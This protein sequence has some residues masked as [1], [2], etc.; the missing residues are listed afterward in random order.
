MCVATTLRIKTFSIVTL[1]KTK[2]TTLRMT[3]LLAF[4]LSVAF[5]LLWLMPLCKVSL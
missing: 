3:I 1:S 4:K 2:R 5:L